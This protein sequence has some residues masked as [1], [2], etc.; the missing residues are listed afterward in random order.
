MIIVYF[1]DVY[2]IELWE[3]E[4]VGGVVRFV[5]KL[6]S[7]RYFNFLV[8]FSGDCLNFLISECFM[9]YLLN[10]IIK[11]NYFSCLRKKNI[12]FIGC[13]FFV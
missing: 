9:Y 7:L 11:F 1:N 13:F 5:I 2:N 12:K 3:K 6:V 8:V 4:L 10:F